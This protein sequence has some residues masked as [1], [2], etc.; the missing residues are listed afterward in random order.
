MAAIA[1]ETSEAWTGDGVV[2]LGF[3]SSAIMNLRC[4]IDLTSIGHK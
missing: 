4:Q 1:S 3:A 2:H